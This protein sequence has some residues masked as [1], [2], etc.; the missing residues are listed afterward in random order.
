MLR[1]DLPFKHP[2]LFPPARGLYVRDWR[3]APIY[4]ESERV[5]SVDL[6]EPL[7]EGDAY[8][9]GFWY[10]MPGINDA[11]FMHLPWRALTDSER[12]DRRAREWE[13]SL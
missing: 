3:G 2:S 4:P 8:G 12:R 10:V 7:P 5:L 11:S 6:W 9:P 13:G 1:E